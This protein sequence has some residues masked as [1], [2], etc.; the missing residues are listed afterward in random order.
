M[1]NIDVNTLNIILIIITF[2]LLASLYFILIKQ[3]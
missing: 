1:V 2:I 3:K